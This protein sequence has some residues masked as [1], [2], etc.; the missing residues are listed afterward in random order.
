MELEKI[1]QRVTDVLSPVGAMGAVVELVKYDIRTQPPTLQVTVDRTE[2]TES[3]NLDEIGEISRRIG[4]LLDNE[5]DLIEQEYVLEVSTP[6]AESPLTQRR[7]YERNI[8]RNLKVKL[9][10]GETLEGTLES[11][12]ATSF[13]LATDKG[14]RYF[15][16]SDVK[17]VKPR[18]QFR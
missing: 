7:H 17:R 5:D 14:L 11:A 13:T 9:V 8:G 2:G 16:Y 1:P 3:L 12:S 18:A 15:D 10:S 4:E 6:G